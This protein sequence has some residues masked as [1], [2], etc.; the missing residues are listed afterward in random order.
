[1]TRIAIA[2]AG[3]A[4]LT[5]AN[6]LRDQAEIV[7]FEKARGVGGRMATRYADPWQF[8]HGAQFFTAQTERFRAFLAP[9]IEAGIVARWDARFAEFIGADRTAQWQWNAER[10]HYVGAPKMNALAKYTAEGLDVRLATRIGSVRRDG[11]D[12][13][14]ADADGGALGRYDWFV[15]T[16]PAPQ[17]AALLPSG[18]AAG[19]TVD[20]AP[21][22]ACFALM[23]GFDDDLSFD[24]DA[25]HVGEA[26]I[27]WMS[28]NSAKPGRDTAPSLLV[29]STNAWADAHKDDDRDAVIAH[30]IA[31]ASRVSSHDLG[32]AAHVALHRWLYANLPRR[33]GPAALIDPER[34]LAACGDWCIHG[35]VEA[36]F[37]SAMAL[38][39]RLE[40]LL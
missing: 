14:L 1:M 22:R 10:P 35:R 33:D 32:T 16:A 18:F 37:T 38:A 15:S 25:A 11:E 9:M 8:D 26:D 20:T 12:W 4:G 2:G 7:L 24:W 21:M 36:A 6:A 34:R 5:L 31:E 13:T 3:L 40:P 28:V 30:L 39:D 27:S 29:H 19:D 23:L 17:S